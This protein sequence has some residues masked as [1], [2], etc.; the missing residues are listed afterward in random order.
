MTSAPLTETAMPWHTA[1]DVAARSNRPL[2]HIQAALAEA[3]GCALADDLCALV[4]VPAFDTAA[5]DGYAVAGDPPWTVAGQVLADRNIRVPPLTPGTAM[6][7]ATGAPVPSGASAVLP[8]E[9]ADHQADSVTGKVPPGQHIRWCGE[10]CAQGTPVLAAGA[11]ITPVAQGLA[12]SLGHDALAVHPKPRVAAFITGDELITSGLPRF[13]AAR[14]AIGPMLTGIVES[15]GGSVIGLEHLADTARALA[16]GL[17]SAK[18][19]VLIVCG[20]SSSGP[21]DHLRTT[22]HDEGAEMLVDGVACRPGHPQLLAS[23]P[24]G[25]PVVGLPGNPYAALVAALT[26]LVPVL[27]ALGGRPSRP[28]GRIQL[29]GDIAAHHRDTRLV[30]ARLGDEQLVPVGHD[31]PGLLWGAAIADV[32]AVVPPDWNG[33]PVQ[34]LHLPAGTHASGRPSVSAGV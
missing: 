13:G 17:G 29:V 24:D 33:A 16:D 3:A 20:A 34:V 5:M 19:D 18:A 11:L 8:Y 26:L 27:D 15:A 32:L 21:A 30:A 10:E 25:R 7:I 4:P 12:A 1:R 6:E 9:H 14:D 31:R 22:L 28:S 23:L 2:P